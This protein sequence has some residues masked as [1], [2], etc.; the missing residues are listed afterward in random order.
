MSLQSRPTAPNY[1]I[2]EIMD[3]ETGAVME[4]GAYSGKTHRQL[5]YND[6]LTLAYWSIESCNFAEVQELIGA[7]RKA[8]KSTA[9]F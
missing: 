3:P 9:A 4:L 2:I 5:A 1:Q 6:R 7:L 8:A